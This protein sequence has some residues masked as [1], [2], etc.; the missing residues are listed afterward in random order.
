MMKGR[1][2]LQLTYYF[3]VLA[4]THSDEALL[5]MIMDGRAKP[6]PQELSRVMDSLY[7]WG[8]NPRVDQDWYDLVL[9]RMGL[10][11]EGRRAGMDK[12]DLIRG[13]I[14]MKVQ[15]KILDLFEDTVAGD[16]VFADWVDWFNGTFQHEVFQ[17]R[18]NFRDIAIASFDYVNN[19]TAEL[20]YAMNEMEYRMR[21]EQ[22]NSD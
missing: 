17:G 16:L 22:V 10:L 8:N 4:N 6:F 2:E 19:S 1:S 3:P 7:W 11:L 14:S 5:E 12:R 9:A 20:E 18:F 13:L 21:P 15:E